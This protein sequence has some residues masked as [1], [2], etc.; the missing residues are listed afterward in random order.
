MGEVKFLGLLQVLQQRAAGAHGSGAV[1]EAGFVHIGKTELLADAGGTGEKFKITRFL[2]RHGVQLVPQEGDDGAVFGRA[3]GEHRF[4]RKK[5]GKFVADVLLA[6]PRE[7]GTAEL[8]GAE[9]AEGDAGAVPGEKDGADVVAALFREHGAVRDG[10]GGDDADDIPLHESLGQCRVFQLFAD[11]DL[12]AFC[13]E[14]CDVAFRAVIGDAAHGRALFGILDIPVPGGER[15]V[16]FPGGGDGV[17][18]EHLIEVAETEE[19]QTVTVLLL[20]LLILALHR[21]QLSHRKPL[22]FRTGPRYCRR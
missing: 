3:G 4:P 18:V 9:L 21:G 16:Q 7:G 19:E 20:D 13:N 15:Q 17:V 6:V 10:T 2:L 5:T 22:P 12:V 14:L 1:L 11:G 8:A